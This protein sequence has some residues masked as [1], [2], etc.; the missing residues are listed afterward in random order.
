VS[1]VF[2]FSGAGF[3]IPILALTMSGIV[4]Y[5][6]CLLSGLLPILLDD[7]HHLVK[8]LFHVTYQLKLDAAPLQVMFLS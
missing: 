8:F 5:D 3:L 2:D 7:S 6:C 1:E 4:S